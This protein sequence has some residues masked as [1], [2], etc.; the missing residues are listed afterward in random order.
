M[1]PTENDKQKLFGIQLSIVRKIVKDRKSTSK[2]SLSGEIR[3]LPIDFIIDKKQIMHLRKS[4]T[5]KTQVNDITKML[6]EDP[7]KNNIITY[8][9]SLLTKYDISLTLS[10]IAL[11]AKYKW[12]K[13]I[14]NR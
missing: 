4:L 7:Y 8:I 13:L 12:N 2:L 11:D 3:E 6:L 9:Y 1:I 5:S 10:Q 14:T